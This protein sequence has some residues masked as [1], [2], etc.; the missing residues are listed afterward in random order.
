[1]FLTPFF[2]RQLALIGWL[3]VDHLSLFLLA[4]ERATWC[5]DHLLVYFNDAYFRLTGNV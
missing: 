4:D 1:M 3:I 5:L 2:A